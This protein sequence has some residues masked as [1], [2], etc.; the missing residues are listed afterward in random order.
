MQT[1]VV[2]ALTPPKLAAR[3]GVNPDKIWHWIAT[4]ELRAINVALSAQGRPRWRITEEAVAEFESLR[5]SQPKI[6]RTRRKRAP[7]PATEQWV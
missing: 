1:E 4:G 6:R 2:R 3:L 5:S 7:L